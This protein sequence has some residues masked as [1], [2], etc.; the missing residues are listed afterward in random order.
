M[1][2]ITTL[3]ILAA[4]TAAGRTKLQVIR[5]DDKNAYLAAGRTVIAID[6]EDWQTTDQAEIRDHNIYYM[7]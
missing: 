6:K 5:T 1:T 3:A 7:R 2:K 4:L